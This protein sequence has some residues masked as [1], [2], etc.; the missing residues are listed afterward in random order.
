[1]PLIYYIGCDKCAC[2]IL[3]HLWVMYILKYLIVP[4]LTFTV[5]QLQLGIH[6]WF[7]KAMGI[8]ILC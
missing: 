8:V 7:S 2:N 3:H 5:Q 4:A 6:V 1:M